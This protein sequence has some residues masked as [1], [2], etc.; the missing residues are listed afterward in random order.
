MRD[1]RKPWRREKDDESVHRP[2]G[3]GRS[4]AARLRTTCS[5]ARSAGQ[6]RERAMNAVR[7]GYADTELRR[8]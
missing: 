6:G 3:D 7:K 8:V 1:G 5:P 4:F 2:G